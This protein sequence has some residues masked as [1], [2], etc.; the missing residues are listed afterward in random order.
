MPFFHITVTYV[1][2]PEMFTPPLKKT[3]ANSEWGKGSGRQIQIT[4]EN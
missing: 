2:V 1:Y 3:D 4:F